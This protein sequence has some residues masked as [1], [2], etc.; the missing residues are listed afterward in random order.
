MAERSILPIFYLISDPEFLKYLFMIKKISARRKKKLIGQL[1]ENAALMIQV[2][3]SHTT[4]TC[5]KR[6]CACHSD[7]SRRHGPNAY[8]NFR[9]ADGRIGG[10]Y[11]APQHVAEVKEAKRAWEDFWQA[12]TRMAALNREDMKSRWQAARKARVSR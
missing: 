9:A 3:L 10:M 7:P 2:G 11:V 1:V 12:A 5:G 6:S 4:R 8:L